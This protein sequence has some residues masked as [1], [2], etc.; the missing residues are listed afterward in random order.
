MNLGLSHKINE[1][2]SI[3]AYGYFS[4]DKFSF[5]HDTTFR[6]RNISGALKWHSIFNDR[7]SMVATVGYDSYHYGLEDTYNKFAAYELKTTIDQVY[8]KLNFK[9]SVTD[10]HTLS[11]GLNATGYDLNPGELLPV[12]DSSLVRAR[13]LSRER[14]LEAAVYLGDTWQI[15]ERLSAC[16][17][18]TRSTTRPA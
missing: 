15:N 9:S 1:R 2:N 12:G 3:H 5:S 10:A 17:A 16:R 13:Y 8:A 4:R 14:A 11:Y 18:N 7:H 6:Y